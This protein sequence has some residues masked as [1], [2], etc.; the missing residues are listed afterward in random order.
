MAVTFVINT[1]VVVYNVYLKWLESHD[2]R[3]RADRIDEFM[4]WVYPI[5]FV[6]SIGVIGIVFL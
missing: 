5:A 1:L 4:D 2:R 3:E 6:V